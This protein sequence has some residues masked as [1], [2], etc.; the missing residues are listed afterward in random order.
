MPY[1]LPQP[2]RKTCE[3]FIFFENEFT[4]EELQKI[5][6]LSKQIEPHSARVGGNINAPEGVLDKKIRSSELFWIH[7]ANEF[8]WLFEK[9]SSVALRCNQNWYN[10]DLSAFGEA[11]Q[12]TRYLAEEEGHYEWHED[13]GANNMSLRKLSMVVM[14][15]DDFEGGELEIFP[16]E[17]I[18]LKKG[19]II[20]FPSYKYHKVHSVT[21]GERWSLVS[22]VS[23]PP[24]R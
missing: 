8:N 6:D 9:M 13:V 23:G 16:Y 5:I 3:H 15:N 14:L 2:V 17:K 10:F 1:L 19:M 7:W 11:L 22:W 18:K 20:C 21:K 12:L 4:D 24:F